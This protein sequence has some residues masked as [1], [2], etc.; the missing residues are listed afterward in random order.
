MKID[1]VIEFL[2]N[3]KR[4]V[5]IMEVCG[6]HTSVI[7]KN[8]VRQLISPSI[9]LVSGP[10]CPVCVTPEKYIDALIEY[11]MKPNYTVLSFGDLFKVPGSKGSL[12]DAKAIGGRVELIY[13]PLDSLIHVK[14]DPERTYVVAA[15]GFET[16]APV[17]AVLLDTVISKNIENIRLAASIKTMPQILDFICAG[18]DID[19][20][21]CPGHV[22]VVTGLTPFFALCEK[23]RKPF[24]VAGFEPE[25]ILAAIYE[26]VRQIEKR[27]P[28]AVNL[29]KG[30][31]TGRPQA[32][33]LELL[34]K[35]FIQSD[36]FWRGIGMIKGS[37]LSLRPEYE[38]FGVN[39]TEKETEA[40]TKTET[41]AKT[42]TGPRT[43]IGTKTETETGFQ[44]ETKTIT[45]IIRSVDSCRCSEVMLGRILPNECPLFGSK[46]TPD[47]PAGA[48]MVS[49]EGSCGIA[50]TQ[51]YY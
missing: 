7:V 37:G 24:I 41:Q 12:A 38:R 15:V 8:G 9:H 40:G 25:H 19:G 51:Y 3:Y 31:V 5:K 29:Y 45:E 32:K 49:A 47:N 22:S 50:Y 18:E 13:S 33:A 2:R 17:Y 35:Y 28:K 23:Y 10:G 26:I 36:A 4:P 14:N 6:S 44:K 30:T 43:E 48:C 11:A 27:E 21:I 20:F 39:V 34:D 42:E 16:T 46:C 1:E